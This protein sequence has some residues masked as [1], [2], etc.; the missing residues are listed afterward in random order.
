MAGA[1]MWAEAL[2]PVPRRPPSEFEW[3]DLLV[4]IEVMPKALRVA[5]EQLPA[6]HPSV[7]PV[8]AAAG[9]R[10]AGVRDFIERASGEPGRPAALKTGAQS[11]A[12]HEDALDRFV[13]IRTRNFAMLQRRGIDVWNWEAHVADGETA[14]IHQVL[15]VLSQEDVKALA[16]L[17]DLTRRGTL[18]C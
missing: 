15:T 8:L 11:T 6:Q 9:D 18:G 13:R 10:E 12:V 4:R 7:L 5:L 1:T 17:R 2:P 3:E 16:A 14:T